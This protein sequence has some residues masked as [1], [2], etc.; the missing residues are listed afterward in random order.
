M[1][2]QRILGVLLLLILLS[3][4][5]FAGMSS[6]AYV[7]S[8]GFKIVEISIED[9]VNQRL[10]TEQEVRSTVNDF[11]E[12]QNDSSAL[13][14][15]AFLLET[16]VLSLPYVAEAQVYWN[17]DSSIV[18]EVVSKEVVAMAYSPEGNAY[19]TSENEVLPQ[20]QKHWLD[21]PIITGSNDSAQLALSGLLLE[22]MAPV[23]PRESVAQITLEAEEVKLVPRAYPHV[24]KAHSDERLERELQKLAAYYAAHSDEELKQIKRIDLRYKNQVVTTTR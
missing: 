21:L 16:S 9:P 6:E 11:F 19:I 5:V 14:L 3:G 15:N 23:M 13:R 24:A 4:V 8:I 22:R 2:K 17:M 18:V 10:V 12:E 7:E 1:K 20:P